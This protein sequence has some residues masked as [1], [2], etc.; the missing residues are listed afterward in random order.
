MCHYNSYRFR[1]R[2]TKRFSRKF[3]KFIRYPGYCKINI[4]KDRKIRYCDLF[5]DLYNSEKIIKK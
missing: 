1:V 4:G 5:L 3:N 2:S